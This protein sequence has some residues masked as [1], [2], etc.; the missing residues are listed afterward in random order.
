MK[1]NTLSLLAAASLILLGPAADA[2][3]TLEL[4]GT[5]SSVAEPVGK[6][7]VA[8]E[9]Y[10]VAGRPEADGAKGM[11]HIYE[12]ATG[13]EVRRLSGAA[14]GDKFGAAVALRGTE[15]VVGSPNAGSGLVQI[16]DIVTGRELRLILGVPGDNLFGYSLACDGDR[17]L[18]GVP[19]FARSGHTD[20]GKVVL[21]TLPLGST[22]TSAFSRV[23]IFPSDPQDDAFYGYSV[24]IHGGIIAV[25]APFFDHVGAANSGK[26]YRHDASA[27]VG[28]PEANTYLSFAPVANDNFGWTVAL[29]PTFIVS[30]VP[31]AN[32][33]AGQLYVSGLRTAVTWTPNGLPGENLGY[34]LAASES[35]IVAG[36]PNASPV[37]AFPNSGKVVCWQIPTDLSAGT[38]SSLSV[39]QPLIIAGGALAGRAVAIAAD[40]IMIGI[41]GSNRIMV[42][43]GYGSLE[44]AG[45][46][47]ADQFQKGSSLPVSPNPSGRVVNTITQAAAPAMALTP[48]SGF[49]EAMVR[50]TV[51]LPGVKTANGVAMMAGTG[52]GPLAFESVNN[53]GP[54]YRTTDFF[55][56][57]CNSATKFGFLSKGVD[58]L[59]NK[60]FQRL[61][62]GTLAPPLDFAVVATGMDLSF[63]KL[64]S[65]SSPRHATITGFEYFVLPATY[66]EKLPGL[67]VTAANDSGI[68]FFTSSAFTATEVFQVREGATVTPFGGGL[69]LGQLNGRCAF[70]KRNLVFSSFLQGTVPAKDTCVLS[71]A[72]EVGTYSDI[73]READGADGTGGAGFS[74]FLGETS[75]S[76]GVNRDCLFRATVIGP[77]VP[78]ISAANNEGLWS[79]RDGAGPILVFRKGDNPSNVFPL[80]VKI[81]RFIRYWIN[82]DR[83]VY[84]LVALSGKGITAANDV[85]LIQSDSAGAVAVRLREGSPAPGLG[86]ARLGTIGFIDARQGGQ[87]TALCSLVVKTGGATAA[88][89]QVL[90]TGRQASGDLNQP[91]LK[92]RKGARIS[93]SGSEV[94]KSI[95]LANKVDD[96]SSGALATG[97]GHVI[98]E[99]GAVSAIVTY[100]D[101]LQVATMVSP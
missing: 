40:R 66:S 84:A 42:R 81:S 38:F 14:A 100:A 33:G 83:S 68:S 94:I 69:L 31:F 65:F 37:P 89:N 21:V 80:G 74:A 59:V 13:K 5:G 53:S 16:F 54:M 44:G 58:L 90:Y 27:T 26:V 19:S 67:P 47:V 23:D 101:D 10:T 63:F 95:A 7:L 76:R 46:A 20:E 11:V 45:Q 93:R 87:W 85:A 92:L 52:Y 1:T 78:A 30:G 29:T 35:F 15:V 49:P 39:A 9:L 17:I 73:A 82:D 79:N 36:C 62:I 12:T 48:G 3:T 18:I 34:S 4:T 71:Y 43:S 24:A 25:G 8:N 32:G 77:A 91:I 61:Y 51:S 50:S 72:P 60:P 64:K 88:N 98:S 57:L 2:Q 96:G 55:D 22:A 97:M 28:A 70:E 99:A 75:N 41:P 86:A 6:V 56:P